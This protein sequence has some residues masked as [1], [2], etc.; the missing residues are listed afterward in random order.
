M[1]ANIILDT[2]PALAD[3]AQEQATKRAARVGR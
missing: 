1:V 2:L 3:V